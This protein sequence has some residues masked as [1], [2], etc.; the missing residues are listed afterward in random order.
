M[1]HPVLGSLKTKFLYI[2]LWALIAVAHFAFMWYYN[3][4]GIIIPLADSLVFNLLFAAIAIPVWYVVGNK[5]DKPGFLNL[6]VN[7]LTSAMIALVIWIGV[8]ILLL[9]LIFPD[10]KLYHSFLISSI[11]WR[12]ISGVFFYSTT[13]L[14]YYITIYY[15]NI[16]ERVKT[17]MQLR[18]LVKQSEL[19]MLKSQI[20]PHFLFNSLNSISSLTMTDAVKAQEMI[21]KLSEYLRYSIAQPLS[22][23]TTL[24]AELENIKRYLEIEQVRFGKKLVYNYEITETCKDMKIPAMI[25]Q[26]LYENAVKHGVYESTGPICVQTVAINE[27]DAL[28]ITITNNFDPD[29]Y[30]RKGSGLGLKNIRE[31]LKLIYGNEL[32][33]K[34]N[35]SQTTFEVILLIPQT[36][37]I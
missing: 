36:E 28:K 26:P 37:I 24:G 11:P 8:G 2:A 35:K 29:A 31:R 20:N 17:E 14:A 3:S 34:I 25:L 1:A 21:I 27:N 33:L 5:P 32:L 9:N 15:E 18:E 12:I 4:F 10:N 19:D 13:V 16:Q 23:L 6:L 7:Q 22:Q 30:I